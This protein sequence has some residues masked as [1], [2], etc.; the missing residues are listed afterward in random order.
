[1]NQLSSID[2][3]LYYAP[4]LFSHVVLSAPTSKSMASGVSGL[5]NVRGRHDCLHALYGPY[6]TSDIYDHGWHRHRM[7]Y[8][9]VGIYVSG[10][11]SGRV[12]W[13]IIVHLYFFP[14]VFRST[15]ARG[16]VL[17]IPNLCV[18]SSITECMRPRFNLCMTVPVSSIANS[19][20]QDVN[21]ILV[22]LTLYV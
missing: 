11:D 1:M 17:H 6:E 4:V 21:I 22:A 12:R 19:C 13:V 20:N 10:A 2:G 18:E 15:E 3:I 16:V 8:M 7:Y 14:I 9:H 5:L